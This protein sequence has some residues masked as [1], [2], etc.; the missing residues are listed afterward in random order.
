MTHFIHYSYGDLEFFMYPQK[1]HTTKV[2]TFWT[3]ELKESKTFASDNTNAILDMLLAE[4]KA[5]VSC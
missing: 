2:E 4:F 1:G 5:P 3:G